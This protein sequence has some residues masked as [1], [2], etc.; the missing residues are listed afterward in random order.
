MSTP[1]SLSIFLAA[2][3]RKL[4]FDYTPQWGRGTPNTFVDNVTF[5]VVLTDK[6]Y[7]YRIVVDDDT[8]LGTKAGYA[9]QADGSQRLNFLE[10]NKGH[11]IDQGRRIRV[12]VVEPDTG[13]QYLVAQW[14]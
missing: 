8:D 14:K 13:N 5:P 9:V 2:T 6:A 4:H 7:T 10:W 12:Y 11:G 1:S 3:L